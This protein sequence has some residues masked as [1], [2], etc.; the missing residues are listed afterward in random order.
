MYSSSSLLH[1]AQPE[2][3]H[4]HA[5]CMLLTRLSRARPNT[6]R[7]APGPAAPA[8]TA[9][10]SQLTTSRTLSRPFDDT[11]NSGLPPSYFVIIPEHCKDPFAKP[12]FLYVV[13]ATA[14]R[15]YHVH[16]LSSKAFC[17]RGRACP[18][19][20]GYACV[21]AS[22]GLKT[23]ARQVAPTLAASTRALECSCLCGSML[24]QA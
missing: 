23:R 21:W 7:C 17:L 16:A 4:V 1:R 11:I 8:P 2:V 6:E 5:R 24:Q 20:T 3:T 12:E 15:S 13:P 9:G 19:F 18:T 14:P 10:E 22:V